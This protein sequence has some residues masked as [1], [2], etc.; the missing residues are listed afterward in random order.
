MLSATSELLGT[1]NVL[2]YIMVWRRR[3]GKGV[4]SNWDHQCWELQLSAST[5]HWIL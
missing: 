5:Y 4:A 1:S 3:A 2:A